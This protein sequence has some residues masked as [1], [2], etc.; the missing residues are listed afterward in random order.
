MGIIGKNSSVQE[1]YLHLWYFDAAMNDKIDP[2]VDDIA[3]QGWCISY[4]F[5]SPSLCQ[6]LHNELLQHAAAHQLHEAKIGKD[7]QHQ[8]RSDFRG[9]SILWLNGETPAQVDFLDI[10]DAYRLKLNQTLF[11]G[12]HELEAHFA[13]YPPGTRYKKH[14]DS[15]Q[16]NNLR[17][18][19]IVAYLNQNWTSEDKG[20]L[21]IYNEREEVVTTVPP[22]AGTLVSYVSERFPHEVM[23]TNKQPVSIAGWFWVRS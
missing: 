22:L 20:E 4:N 14:L 18:I 21:V 11:T 15:F 5:F 9:D 6:A 12:L 16:N 2:I 17:R 7:H 8:R 10:M 19:T 1:N 23:P 3:E 13:L